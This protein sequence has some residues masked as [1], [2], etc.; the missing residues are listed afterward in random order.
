MTDHQRHQQL[1][2]AVHRTLY[3]G[4]AEQLYPSPVPDYCRD[5]NAAALVLEVLKNVAGR[6]S[7]MGLQWGSD[8]WRFYIWQNGDEIEAFSPFPGESICRVYL[9]AVAQADP[10]SP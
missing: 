9:R 8:D 4:W 6:H 7:E 3:P 1:N 10:S 2:L 5:L